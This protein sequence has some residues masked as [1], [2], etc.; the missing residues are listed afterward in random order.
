MYNP[1]NNLFNL[2]THDICEIIY[3]NSGNISAIIGEKVYKL[4]KGNLVIFRSNIP[5]RI[6]IDKPTNYERTNILFDEKIFASGI[7]DKIS[8]D[9]DVIKCAG[10][11]RITELF[12]KLDYYFKTFE[13]DDFKFLLTNIVEELLFNIYTESAENFNDNQ[14][15][16]HPIIKSSIEYINKHYSEPVTIDDI[17]T[18]V[19]VTK[20]HLHHLF[21]ENLKISPKKYVNMKR[22]TKAQKLISNGEKPTTV[23]TKCGF[24]DYGTFFRNYTN[25]FGYSPSEIDKIASERKIEY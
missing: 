22:L 21:V 18:F 2:H 14:I 3:L 10:N 13:K 6:K 15:S 16:V 11:N 1:D 5:H 24:T 17:C 19:C 23:Y 9:L 8:R 20:S 12:D 25:Y 7:F 4:K